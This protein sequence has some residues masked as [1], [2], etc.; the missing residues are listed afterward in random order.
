[1]RSPVNPKWMFFNFI[2]QSSTT[3]VTG[4]IF[5]MGETGNKVTISDTLVGN[6]RV[7]GGTDITLN[8][9]L[10]FNT[11]APGAK[12]FYYNQTSRAS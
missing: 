12:V 10:A 11:L 7:L 5:V 8:C 4:Q 9:A 1:M 6:W 3:S 2:A